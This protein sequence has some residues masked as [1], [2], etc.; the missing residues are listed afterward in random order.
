MLSGMTWGMRKFSGSN[1]GRRA[2]A[3]GCKRP[4]VIAAGCEHPCAVPPSTLALL[5]R[6]CRE[7]RP[8]M[9]MPAATPS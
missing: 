2:F 4:C 5:G 1:R 6:A 9:A 8:H 7:P 3:A